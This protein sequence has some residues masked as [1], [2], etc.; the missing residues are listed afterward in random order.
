MDSN[1]SII[2]IGGLNTDIVALGAKKLLKSGEH[3][4]ADKL[5]IG[6]GGKSRN[7]AQMIAALSIKKNVA[8]MGKS[9]KDPFG[10]WKFPIDSL[11]EAGVNIEY[12]T[13]ASFEETKQFPG[14][15]LIPVD[16]QG[17]NQIYVLPG[18]NNE[19]LSKDIDNASNLFQTIAKNKGMLVLTLE[20][21]CQTALYAIKK[22]NKLDI[23][24]LFDPGGIDEEQ[25]YTELLKQNIYLLKPNEH[26]A[27]VLTGVEVNDYK[28]SKKAAEK[29]LQQG[30]QNVFITIGSQG[31]Y[32]FN[33]KIEKHI[34]IPD[35]KA[36]NTK[37]ETGCGDQAMATF[38][39]AIN[40]G[41]TEI[42]AATT[43]ILAGTLQFYNPGI[44]P[45]TRS[46]L[47]K[48]EK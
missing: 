26:E 47:K 23:K 5:H 21:P 39:V 1:L 14:I 36:S 27:T 2:V 12:V 24:V 43:A 17:R 28:T 20:L 22:A 25:N 37:D 6:A 15:A 45:V 19:F 34:P 44:Q 42:E 31:G 7:I 35:I 3:T 8:M 32:F 10:L 41:K 33:N 29:M 16:K 11:K 48:Y 46:D 4:Y 9:S 40:E 30:V 13:I 18:I 38:A